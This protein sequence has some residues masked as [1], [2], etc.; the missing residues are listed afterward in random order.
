MGALHIGGALVEVD[1]TDFAAVDYDGLFA[2]VRAAL[3][4]R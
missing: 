4:E 2:A 1:T 3:T